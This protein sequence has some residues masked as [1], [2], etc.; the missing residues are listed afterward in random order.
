M[1]T[2]IRE[3]RV[4]RLRR[5]ST[6]HLVLAAAFAVSRLL[7]G[8]AG[9]RFDAS[10]LTYA[11]QLLD[12]SLLEDRLAESV[13]YLHAQPP[14]FNL[15]VGAVLRWSP[16]TPETSL[17]IAYLACGI[18]LL[19]ALHDLVRRLGLGRRTAVIVALAIGCSPAVV[20]YENWLSYEYPV[21]TML[22]V[23]VD[24]VTRYAGNPTSTRFFVAAMG[25]GS[26]ATLTRSL[27]H[28]VWLVAVF[29]CVACYR[30]PPKRIDLLYAALPLLVVAL[31]IAKNEALFGTQLSSWFGYGVHKVAQ[32]P[33]TDAQKQQLLAEGFTPVDPGPCVVAHPD[34][35]VLAEV[36][37]RV[38]PAEGSD[39]IENFNHE[40]LIA[41]YQ[42]LQSD[43]L[44]ITRAHPTWVARNVAGGTEIWASPSTLNPF[45]FTNRNTISGADEIH[46]RVVMLDVAWDPPV[47]IPTAWPVAVSAPDHSFHLSITMVLATLA[48]SAAAVVALARWR[49]RDA[50][51]LA[52]LVGGGT[53]AFVTVAGNLFEYGE[54]NRIRFVVEPLTLALAAVV[55]AQVVRA[56]QQRR[57]ATMDAGVAEGE[58]ISD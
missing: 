3:G 6:E 40:C 33:L 53:V 52:M 12:P 44:R 45:V 20:L 26:L 57:R 36:N 30:R 34:V 31:V 19:F 46:R 15:F 10:G 49:R 29:V 21:A 38:A 47:A 42:G 7:Y 54:N 1:A 58:P 13:W 35:P 18:V 56:V 28:P 27:L 2:T 14:A 37:K 9:V 17:Q 24:L 4:D 50:T 41:R 16:L 22:V 8:W 39:P 51:S 48:V 5:P 55:V 25:V 23:L 43:A 32:S 11:S